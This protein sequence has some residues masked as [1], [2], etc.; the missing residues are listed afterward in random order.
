MPVANC[1]TVLSDPLLPQLLGPV[2]PR[3]VIAG[4]FQRGGPECI[5]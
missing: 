5:G 1:L 3:A 4:R 2:R